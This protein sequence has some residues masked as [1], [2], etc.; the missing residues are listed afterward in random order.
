MTLHIVSDSLSAS[1][2][3]SVCACIFPGLTGRAAP[4][5]ASGG[6][7]WALGLFLGSMLHL[8]PSIRRCWRVRSNR[9]AGQT[10]FLRLTPSHY[11]GQI[12]DNAGISVASTKDMSNPHHPHWWDYHLRKEMRFNISHPKHMEM[13]PW[14]QHYS[15]PICHQEKDK[16]VWPVFLRS[17]SIR[18]S[19]PQR[20]KIQDG[21]LFRYANTGRLL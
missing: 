16:D 11:S 2:Q 12:Q 6:H 4:L 10:D 8:V 7:T 18:P 13:L 5:V 14:G 20:K 19:S 15:F 9:G 17:T 21:A 1:N 3:S